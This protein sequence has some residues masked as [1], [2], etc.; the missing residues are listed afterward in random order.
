MIA[1]IAILINQY[2]LNHS[3]ES[4]VVNML[5]KKNTNNENS[6]AFAKSVRGTCSPPECPILKKGII[7]NVYIKN[8]MIQPP[9]SREGV[10][11]FIF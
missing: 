7:I 3:K 2:F 8:N 6:T 5:R 11:I 4:I 9:Y 1:K 10:Q